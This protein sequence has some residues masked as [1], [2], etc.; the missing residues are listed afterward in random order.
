M[1]PELWARLNPLF[2]AAVEMPPDEQN[3]FIANACRGDEELRKE[4]QALVDAH[5]RQEATTDKVA[6]GLK[7]LINK[8]TAR[9]R[10]G[11]IV[12]GRFRIVRL[13]GS[14]GMGEVYEAFDLELSQ[15]VALKSI[16]P[17]IAGNTGVLARF[18]KEVQ[19]ARRLTGPNLC[20]IHEL[21]IAPGNI[22]SPVDAF[23]TMELLEGTTL[24]DELRQRGPLLWTRVREIAMDI[25]TALKTMHE[26]GIIHRDLKSRNIMLAERNGKL[27]AV[28]MDFGLAHETSPRSSDAET[29]LTGPGTFIG[30]PQYMAPE[31][32]EGKDLSP[33]TDIYATGI[34][35]YELLTGRHPFAA[36]NALE[37]AVLRGKKPQSASSL[38]PDVP[39]GIDLII[40]KCL[41]FDPAQRFQSASELAQALQS[42]GTIAK[43]PLRAMSPATKRTAIAALI[44]VLAAVPFLWKRFSPTYRIPDPRALQWYREGLAALREGAYLKAARE[45]REA[46]NIDPGFDLAHARLAQA[47]ADLDFTGAAEHEMLIA[48][49]PERQRN[50]PELDR[51]YINAVRNTLTHDFDGSVHE[52]SEILAHLPE[53]QKGFG[54][55]DLGL[56]QEKA[57][58]LSDAINSFES[59]AALTPD[60]PALYVHLG[61][62]RRLQQDN[63]GAE[64]AFDKAE[65]LYELKQNLEGLGEVAFQRGHSANEQ[66]DSAL[67]RSSLEHCLDI[68]RQIPSIQLEVR[69]LTQLSNAEYISDQNDQA[70]AHA[71]KAIELA[72]ENNLEY[73]ATDG[74]IREANALFGKGSPEDLANA[75][76]LLL[77]ALK[78]AQTNQHPR[79]EANA[80]FSLASLS[81]IREKPDD[82]IRRAQ[83]ALKIYV[84]FGFLSQANDTGI[85][86][87]RG[88]RRKG[89]LSRALQSS[90]ELLDVAQRSGRTVLVEDAQATI[91]SVY[92]EL[93]DY[94]QA[95][96][97]Y[98]EAL[99]LS[100]ITNENVPYQTLSCA[101]MLWRLGRYE[102][103]TAMLASV[104]AEDAKRPDIAQSMAHTQA[105]MLLSQRR[106]SETMKISTH[107][108]QQFPQLPPGTIIDFKS[109]SALAMARSGHAREAQDAG[110][111]I[112]ALAQKTLDE[113]LIADANMTQA[114]LDLL[115]GSPQSARTLAESANLYFAGKKEIE[116]DWMSLLCAAEAANA[117]GEKSH[118]AQLAKQVV[119]KLHN[120]EQNWS[121]PVFGQYRSR[122]DIQ[123][124]FKTLSKLETQ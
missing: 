108:L 27:C 96:A 29:T 49:T 23:L 109:M 90:F 107:A 12:H 72:Q 1:T 83:A 18:R 113:G 87:V 103:A 70:I 68:A 64:A 58:K 95:L 71:R 16:R 74:L 26:A 3:A 43:S 88:E 105:A 54:Y 101:E 63:G 59:A 31:Q 22:G 35:M 86:I 48:S 66:G 20:R 69:A 24:A 92:F 124:A 15:S 9:Y 60:N 89:H 94:P 56:A 47:W 39:R 81:D 17:D 123:T 42:P 85:L 100:R 11:D 104:T 46:V 78:A 57:G 44:L 110:Q 50:L 67:A 117:T 32:F 41:R 7:A 79:L 77:Q 98:Q 80:Q 112:V 99:R 30:T 45:L 91:G 62:I 4:L 34:V 93:E 55:L 121:S 106:F 114:T 21:F 19:L 6:E 116:S 40:E 120:I 36:S 76:N 118:S 25:C 8:A 97:H 102:D 52:Y 73:W 28:V 65:H 111:Q 13:L 38:R 2:N 53:D 51:R 5:A 33:A 122:P 61:V 84:D 75:E 119:D 115:A 14:G 37:A 82:Q 10:P